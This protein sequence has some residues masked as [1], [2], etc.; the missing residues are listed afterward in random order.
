MIAFPI[1][2]LKLMIKM[3]ITLILIPITLMM[4]IITINLMDITKTKG[5]D[6]ATNIST[7]N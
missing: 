5:F 2:I 7:T 6:K 1:K 4:I 3:K